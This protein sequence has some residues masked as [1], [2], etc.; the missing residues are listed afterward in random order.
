MPSKE[1]IEYYEELIRHQMVPWYLK[2]PIDWVF[3]IG[4]YFFRFL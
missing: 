1:K 4:K 2:N 3:D